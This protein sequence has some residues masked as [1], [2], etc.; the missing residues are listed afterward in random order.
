LIEVSGE[1]LLSW[2]RK[3]LEYGGSQKELDWL[4]DM[5]ANLKWEHLQKVYLDPNKS[6]FI[7]HPLHLVSCIWKTY[8]STKEPLQ[9]LVG[10]C[11]WRDF[12]L[13]I[14]SSALIPR[15]ETERIVDLALDK[16]DSNFDGIW[17]DLGTGSG[18]LAISLARNFPKANG[19]AVDCC[20][21]VLDLAER[22]LKHLAPNSFVELHLGDWWEPINP[23]WGELNLVVANP[24]YIPSRL[25]SK[26]EK[27]VKN[28]EPHLALS[29][30][31]DGLFSL[32][33]IIEYSIK[34]LSKNGWLIVEHHYD[35]SETVCN[36]MSSVGLKDVDFSLDFENVRRFSIG[37]R[38]ID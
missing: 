3:Q 37:R 28:F 1:K 34:G 27:K 5:S 9:Y 32:R 18:A 22:N 7:S 30:G 24:P 35:Q 8:L 33:K 38:P 10:R 11:P 6:C 21:D 36:L 4:L 2:R 23:W 17:A 15:Q 26:L 25:I 14:N 20:K 31:L 13:E 16:F 12:E 19:H 29:G